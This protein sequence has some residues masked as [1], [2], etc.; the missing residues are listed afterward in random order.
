VN[1]ETGEIRVSEEKEARPGEVLI[2]EVE[3]RYLEAFQP[4][5]RYDV[6]KQLRSK[7]HSAKRRARKEIAKQSRR[8]NRK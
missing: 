7:N 5:Q 6:L 3:K 8:R 1:I 4:E 2:S